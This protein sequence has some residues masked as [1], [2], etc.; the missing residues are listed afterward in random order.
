MGGTLIRAEELESGRGNGED[1]KEERE[2]GKRV[3]SV[4]VMGG[5]ERMEEESCAGTERITE[6]ALHA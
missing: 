5:H 2:D 3:Q 6:A 4:Q 1:E